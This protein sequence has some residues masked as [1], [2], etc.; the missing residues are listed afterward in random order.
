MSNLLSPDS[1]NGLVRSSRSLAWQGI[2]L[3]QRSHPGGEWSFPA[4]S[5]HLICLYLGKPL[6]LEQKRHGRSHQELI[7]QGYSMIVPAGEP[8]LWQHVDAA[9]H[10]HLRLDPGSIARVA[11]EMTEIDPSKIEIVERF[12]IQDPQIEHIGL[13]LAAEL[14]AGGITGKL[15]SESLSTALIAHLLKHHTSTNRPNSFSANGLPPF[16]LRQ[17]LD[18]LHSHLSSDLSLTEL[19]QAVGISQS[20]FSSL[21]RQSTGLSPYQYLIQ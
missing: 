21:F 9:A 12:A 2:I 4:S 18:Y 3:E 16:K 13:A 19:A 7:A 1:N 20:H 8:S 6:W 5:E 15:Y 14:E 11:Q 10:I 17:V